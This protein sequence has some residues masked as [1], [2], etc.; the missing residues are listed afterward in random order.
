MR[1]CGLEFSAIAQRLESETSLIQIEEVQARLT[2]DA[3]DVQTEIQLLRD[4]LHK[5]HDPNKMQLIQEMI[6]VCTH[7]MLRKLFGTIDAPCYLGPHEP[8]VPHTRTS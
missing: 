8:N 4:E 1:F 6:S 7:P 3:E 5:N 2:K